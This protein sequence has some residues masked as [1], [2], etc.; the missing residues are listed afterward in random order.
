M[1]EPPSTGASP[2]PAASRQIPRRSRPYAEIQLPCARP[3][4]PPTSSSCSC[5]T[6][7]VRRLLSDV[8]SSSY[9]SHPVLVA[10]RL[11]RAVAPS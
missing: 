10:D 9:C 1:R 7:V 2:S 6:L 8:V 5:P 11:P 3:P 4:P